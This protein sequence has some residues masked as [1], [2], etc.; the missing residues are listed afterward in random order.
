[1]QQNLR[2]AAVYK[3]EILDWIQK[4]SFRAAGSGLLAIAFI[5]GAAWARFTSVIGKCSMSGVK[6]YAYLRDLF[7]K[8]ANGHLARKID[9]PCHGQAPSTSSRQNGLVPVSIGAQN[10]PPFG[11]QFCPLFLR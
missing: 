3:A 8:L 10:C 4:L 9:A 6:P 5:D 7:T 1:M 11:A 2:A